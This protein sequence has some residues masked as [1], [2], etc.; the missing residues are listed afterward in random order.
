MIL[1]TGMGGRLDTTNVVERPCAAVITSIGMDHTQYL[2]DTIE[3]I[4]A[5]KAGI[6][7]P[8]VPVIYEAKN[9]EVCCVIEDRLCEMGGTGIPVL[10]E[11]AGQ[12]SLEGNGIEA[13]FILSDG[14]RLRARLP[15]EGSYQVGNAALAVRTAET[16]RRREPKRFSVLT[17]Q[18]ISEGLERTRWPGR[19]EEI[20]SNIYLDGAHNPDGIEAFL[21]AVKSISSKK[22]RPVWLLFG[23]VSDKDY[24]RMARMLTDGMDWQEIGVARIDSERGLGEERLLEIFE[25]E[26]SCPVFSY[27]TAGEALKQMRQKAK[28]GILFCA[29]S[30]YLIGELRRELET[31][32]T[33]V[34]PSAQ[35]E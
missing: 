20:C 33:L 12:I 26:A 22:Q 13:E 31:A 7:K 21:K 2:G 6:I 23:A 18:V 14:G 27:H 24:R 5:E 17:D 15:F 19:M 10:P 25:A 4:T 30:L 29:G 35:I 28:E 32:Q 16:L 9:P 34:L 11:D 1:E 3:K 8:R